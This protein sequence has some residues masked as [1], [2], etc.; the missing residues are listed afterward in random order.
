[1]TPLNNQMATAVIFC[2]ITKKVKKGQLE[3]YK[4]I[5]DMQPKFFYK[6]TTYEL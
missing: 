4:P 1:M 6:Y 3:T 2:S 5:T